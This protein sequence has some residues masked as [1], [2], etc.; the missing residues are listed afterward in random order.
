MTATR[1][2]YLHL[3]PQYHGIRRY[4]E[5]LAVEAKRRPEIEVIEVDLNLTS[6]WKLNQFLLINAAKKLSHVDVVH[7]QYNRVI[8]GGGNAWSLFRN[9]STFFK[10]CKAP[11]VVT[12]HDIPK[13]QVYFEWSQDNSLSQNTYLSFIEYI[14]YMYGP[15]YFLMRWLLRHSKKVFVCTQEESKRLYQRVGQSWAQS[16]CKLIRIPHFVENREI[17]FN[18]TQ[19][20]EKLG[21]DL[22]R[23]IVTLLGWIHPGKG[24][25]I[26]VEAL[27]QLPL[28]IEMIFAGQPS[29]TSKE[30]YDE[31]LQ[32]T[33]KYG[34][35]N[36]LKITGYLADE[37]LEHYLLATDLAICPFKDTSASGSISTWISVKRSILASDLS[38]TR[39]YNQLVS[40]AIHLFTPYTASSLA[41]AIQRCL[42]PSEESHQRLEELREKLAISVI[43]DQHLLHYSQAAQL[44]SLPNEDL[45]KSA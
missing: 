9:L 4:G 16:Q 39:E 6:D 20:R 10:Y 8:W 31:L 2:G 1:I 38:Q 21:L 7:F 44:I 23:K 28:D 30:F 15:N 41:Q 32:L 37:E 42:V 33:N 45:C 25:Q 26:A 17:S 34:V 27:A 5:F 29:E 24:Y 18:S 14:R 35:A 43:T 11:L 3:G 22:N 12:L 40:G 13:W 19:A 36:R